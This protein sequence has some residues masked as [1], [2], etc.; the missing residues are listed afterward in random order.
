MA[1]PLMEHATP[2]PT[3]FIT[4]KAYD[5]IASM[6]Y[7][8]IAF[9]PPSSVWAL[10]QLSLVSVIGGGDAGQC[11]TNMHTGKGIL[12]LH[13]R[14][15]MQ[16]QS[17]RQSA[18][19]NFAAH[20]QPVPTARVKPRD[21]V[22]MFEGAGEH[23]NIATA[24]VCGSP[25]ADKHLQILCSGSLRQLQ[26]HFWHFAAAVMLYAAAVMRQSAALLRSSAAVYVVTQRQCDMFAA[27]FNGAAATVCSMLQVFFMRRAYGV[28]LLYNI[29][30]M[31][32]TVHKQ[33]CSCC[34]ESIPH[35]GR[36][37]EQM[38]RTQHTGSAAHPIHLRHFAIIG[39]TLVPSAAH[40]M[41]HLPHTDRIIGTPARASLAEDKANLYAS[42]TATRP[43]KNRTRPTPN[44]RESRA[45]RGP[46]P[47]EY[48]FG[49]NV[50]GPAEERRVV[51]ASSSSLTCSIGDPEAGELNSGVGVLPT[52]SP[53]ASTSIH[54]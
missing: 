17:L 10:L 15:R 49:F 25:A 6:D 7:V 53:S 30:K 22:G 54:S 12:P 16:R 8:I 39:G 5:Y 34:Q 28:A 47:L 21:C 37:I 50:A 29:G 18:A 44:Q 36:G 20:V 2:L 33:H 9:Q 4:C 42:H 14:C 13:C 38:R 51:D 46:P 41:R 40:H 26:R 1:P 27:M 11:T 31:Y 35:H 24:A 48:I 19:V 3:N 43:R 45:P 32:L 23:L 52:N